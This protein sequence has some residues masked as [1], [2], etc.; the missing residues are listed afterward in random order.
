[1]KDYIIQCGVKELVEWSSR[2]DIGIYYKTLGWVHSVYNELVKY[3]TDLD[4]LVRAHVDRYGNGII[5]LKN[6]TAYHFIKSSG[7]TARGRRFHKIYIQDC[8]DDDIINTIIEPSIIPY[9]D[10]YMV[11]K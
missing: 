11:T 1:M 2:L 9:K 7:E 4:C 5:Q 6:G 8:I 10:L 3:F